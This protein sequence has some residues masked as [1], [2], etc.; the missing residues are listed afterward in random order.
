M[1]AVCFRGI[2]CNNMKALW[3]LFRQPVDPVDPQMNSK[4]LMPPQGTLSCFD[5]HATICFRTLGYVPVVFDH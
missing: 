3:I 5:S 4:C 1:E 2:K